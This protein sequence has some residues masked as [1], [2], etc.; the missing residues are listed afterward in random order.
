MYKGYGTT[1]ACLERM[2]LIMISRVVSVFMNTLPRQGITRSAN[3]INCSAI[4]QYHIQ[5][6][7]IHCGLLIITLITGSRILM[8]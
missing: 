4:T 6:I 5:I 3:S 7:Y 2:A 8:R 1:T